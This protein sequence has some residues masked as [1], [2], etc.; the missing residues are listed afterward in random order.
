V[1]EI[2]NTAINNT[3][4]TQYVATITT[5]T[6]LIYRRH[7]KGKQLLNLYQAINIVYV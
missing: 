3:T 2:N 4:I 6:K 1:N 5:C 7:E